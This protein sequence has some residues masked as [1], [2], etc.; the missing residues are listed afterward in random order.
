MHTVRIV[1]LAQIAPVWLNRSATL[2]K[3][4]QSVSQAADQGA[5]LVTFGESLLPGYPFWLERTG[6]RYSIHPN[7]NAFMHTT[8]KRQ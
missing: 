2:E 7:K 4:M 5:T 8:C 3:I 6:A 1:A